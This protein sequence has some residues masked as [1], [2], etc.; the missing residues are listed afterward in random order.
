MNLYELSVAF[1]EVQNMELDPEVMKDTLDSI[2]DAIENKAENIAKLVRNLESDV[3]AY[4]E[5]EDRLKTKR[6][7]MENKVKWLKTY[8]EDNMKLTGKTKFK[9]GMFNFSI[10]KNPVSVNITDENILPEDYL[11]PQPP[12]VDKTSLK[13]ALKS[14][15]EVPGAELKQ[16]E[17]LRIR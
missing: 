4:K 13:E 17:G 9:S 16:T 5:E 14:G 11:I 15:I 8:L 7:A 10:Q 3:S 1:Q 6:Q 12:K 2:E